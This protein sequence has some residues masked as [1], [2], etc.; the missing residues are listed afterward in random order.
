[1][2]LAKGIIIGAWLLVGINLLMA[3][4]AIGIF[5]RMTPAIADILSRNEHSLQACEEMLFSVALSSKKGKNSPKLRKNF[6]SAFERALN[7]VTEIGESDALDR[8]EANFVQAFDGDQQAFEATVES[9][10]NLGNINRKA[11]TIADENAQHLGLGGAWGIV[12]MAA[13]SFLVGIIFIRYLV[14]KLLSP[15]EEIKTVL[16]A[17]QNGQTR[18][19]CTGANLSPD[20]KAIYGNINSLIDQTLKIEF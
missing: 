1:M 6:K 5:M 14:Q 13:C 17:H 16:V 11:M 3:F 20:M 19:R 12:F 15:L 2:H 18:R 10:V 9:I 7:N 4:G 8:I